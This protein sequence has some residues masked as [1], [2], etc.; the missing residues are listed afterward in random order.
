MLTAD[1]RISA[2]ASDGME[3]CG[4][5]RPEGHNYWCLF[6][7]RSVSELTGVR[8]PPHREHYWGNH[9]RDDAYSWAEMIA[10]LYSLAAQ[11]TVVAS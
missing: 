5:Y 10:A 2:V 8:V 3:I 11:R 7:T 9:G 1:S 6:V 4:A